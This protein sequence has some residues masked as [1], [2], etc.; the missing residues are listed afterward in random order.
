MQAVF[1][2]LFFIPFEALQPPRVLPY[3]TASYAD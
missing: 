3:K 1:L 2:C